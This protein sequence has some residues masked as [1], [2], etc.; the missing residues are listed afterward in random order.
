MEPVLVA[1]MMTSG[2]MTAGQASGC[3]SAGL[4]GLREGKTVDAEKTAN[5]EK[6]ASTPQR[7]YDCG[8]GKPEQKKGAAATAGRRQRLIR[9][10]ISSRSIA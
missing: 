9:A 4:S 6:K 2:R 10:Q 3:I 1:A 5:F 8:G 7:S